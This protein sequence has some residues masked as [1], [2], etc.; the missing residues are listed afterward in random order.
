MTTYYQIRCAQGNSI[1]AGNGTFVKEPEWLK[2]SF[3]SNI[4]AA[5]LAAEKLNEQGYGNGQ[6]SA[7]VRRIGW[8]SDPVSGVLNFDHSERDNFVETSSIKDSVSKLAEETNK[9]LIFNPDHPATTLCVISWNDCAHPH[10]R[11]TV[12]LRQG[13]T[14]YYHDWDGSKCVFKTYD[15]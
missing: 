10:E 4:S 5:S 7:V 1:Y 11:N 13:E 14:F 8:F 3:F 15:C 12:T 6:C 9:N 2:G